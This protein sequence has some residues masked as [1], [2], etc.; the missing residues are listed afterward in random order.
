MVI[1]LNR[2]VDQLLTNAGRAARALA[3]TSAATKDK[4]LLTA[5]DG[6]VAR[7]ATLKA[8]NAKD[9]E[10]AQAAG[11][12]SAMI[13]R[14]RL[15][16][17]RI[18]QMADGLR[19]IVSLRDPVGEVITGW[20]RPNGLRIQKVRVPIGV[21]CMVYESRP[22]VTADAAALCIKAG[23][24]VILR[25]GKEAMNSN[26]AIHRVLADAFASAGL[27]ADSAQI[28]ATPDRAAIDLL[29]AAEGRL[30]LVIP[31]GGEGLIR[32]IVEKS[33]VP[34]IKHYK[35]V[36]H[37]FVDEGADLSMAESVCFN[38]K[39]QRPGVCN[40]LETLLVH[41]AV[42]AEFLPKMCA[43]L[44]AA[45][46][47]VRGCE[48]TR[49]IVAD[50]KPATEQDWYTEY[51][52]LI[53]SVRVLASLDEALEHIA[54]YGSKHS[55]AIVTRDLARATRFT[56]EVD[57]CA[58]FVN[59]STRFNDGGEFGMG[60]EIGISTDKLHARGPMALPELTSYK[61]VV[62]GDG[63]VRQ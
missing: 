4:A 27:D 26:I 46:G 53:V 33:K 38:A 20:T 17:K 25:G 61:Y 12:S 10:A 48:K 18:G 15:N 42:A 11:L 34:V 2:Y 19:T 3:R 32:A 22:N 37:T 45:G 21:I 23:N 14:L 29:I 55:D 40:A 63:Q 47:E 57:S 60:A 7:G 59:C 30:D 62:L 36:C 31:R 35:G 9:V 43:R 52:D 56:T 49:K 6:L 8:A 54:K 16:D 24:A 58:V 28:V 13:D 41:E 50:L 1:E 39:C 5:A 51:N 44:A